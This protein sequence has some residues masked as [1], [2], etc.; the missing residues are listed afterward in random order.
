MKLRRAL[1]TAAATTALAPFALLTAPTAFADTE[2]PAPGT[3]REASPS[4][5]TTPEESPGSAE[6]PG[7]VETTPETPPA[8]TV[9][10]SAPEEP[11]PGTTGSTS[12]SPASSPPTSPASG[13]P[14]TSPSGSASPSTSPTDDGD[15]CEVGEEDD[16][17]VLVAFSGLP[18]KLARGSGWHPFALTFVNETSEPVHNLV[19]FAGV[20]GDAEG[21]RIFRTGQ[22]ALQAK[23]PGTGAWEPLAFDEESFDFLGS[24][25]DLAPHEKLTYKL[26]LDVTSK[27]PVGSAFTLGA[28]VYDGADDPECL[29]VSSGGYGFQIVA[30]GTRTAGTKP[31]QGGSVPLPGTAASASA[32]PSAS[33]ATGSLASTGGD[34]TLAVLGLAGGI[35]VLAGAGVVFAVRRRGDAAV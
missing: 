1:V 5:T 26:R 8:A 35:A 3:T 6:T 25:Q 15:S 33:P 30:P 12:P 16:A 23:N 31:T 7:S 21:L 2:S 4:D 19:A 13:G 34:G 22:V 27:A 24:G 14:S 18:G 29:R 28:G 20:S 11:A 10:E 9:T 32:S 17:A